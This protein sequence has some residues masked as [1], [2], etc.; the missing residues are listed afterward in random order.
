MTATISID[1]ETHNV[2]RP[3]GIFKIEN[4]DFVLVDTY[5]VTFG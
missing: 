2:R 3:I 4:Q 5:D 1:P